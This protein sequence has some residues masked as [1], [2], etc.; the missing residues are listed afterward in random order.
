MMTKTRATVRRP[1][2]SPRKVQRRDYDALPDIARVSVNEA[3]A[4]V[5]RSRATVWAW[6]KKGRLDTPTS[7]P[8]G[9]R[10]S[11]S[12]GSV[13]RLLSPLDETR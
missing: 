3:A 2:K 1:K 7:I 13:R 9:S 12:W 8:E 4:I 10:P 11:L 5:G 6:I